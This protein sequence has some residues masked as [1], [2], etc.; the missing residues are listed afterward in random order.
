MIGDMTLALGALEWP[1]RTERLL[2]RPMREAD[3]EATWRFRRLEEVARWLTTMPT[4]LD[5]H[6]QR[7]E[8]PDRLAA[9]LVFELHGT[10]IGDL[11]VAPQDCWAQAEVA[12]QARDVQAAL[13]WCVDPAY[14]GRGYATEA[15]EAVL[16]ICF[17]LLGLRR[18]TAGCFADN[19]A[20]RRLMERV[21]MRREAHTRR[22]SLHRS[23]AWL[24][25][26]TYAMLADEWRSRHTS[27]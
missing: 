3:V 6:R 7:F 19:E 24:D 1:I 26:M 11:L 18:V 4:T 25:A 8:A 10:V 21:G 5:Q 9:S 23:G 20:S 22:D 16:R 12:D 15:V 14:G 27:T 2:V 13:G 17:E